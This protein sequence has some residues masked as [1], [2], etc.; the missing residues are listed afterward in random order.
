MINRGRSNGRGMG[1]GLDPSPHSRINGSSNSNGHGRGLLVVGF[2]PF[3]RTMQVNEH[4]T[5][6]GRG[7]ESNHCYS[8]PQRGRG[9]VPNSIIGPSSPMQP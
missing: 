1:Q 4:N 7:R 9:Q 6:H 5:S 3:G 8:L 2:T